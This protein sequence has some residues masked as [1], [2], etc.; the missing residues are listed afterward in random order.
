MATAELLQHLGQRFRPVCAEHA[1]DLIRR[2]GRIGQRS[3]QVEDCSYRHFTSRADGVFHGAM[4]HGREH[5]ADAHFLDTAPDLL[6][7]KLQIDACRFQHVSA[8]RFA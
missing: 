4:V 6:R 8:A 1:N 7:T 2:A 3:E 5:E